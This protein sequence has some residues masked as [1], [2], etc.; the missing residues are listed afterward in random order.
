MMNV[1]HLQSDEEATASYYSSTTMTSLSFDLLLGASSSVKPGQKV[2]NARFLNS[3]FFAG[4][5][6]T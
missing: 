1:G 6:P 3:P 2:A 4:H 5:R